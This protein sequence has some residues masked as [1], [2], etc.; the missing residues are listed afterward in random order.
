MLSCSSQHALLYRLIAYAKALVSVGRSS[1]AKSFLRN[2]FCNNRKVLLVNF[3]AK[4]KSNNEKECF[5]DRRSAMKTLFALTRGRSGQNRQ[6]ERLTVL[7]TTRELVKVQFICVGDSLGVL[8][9]SL[10]WLTVP[11]ATAFQISDL[12]NATAAFAQDDSH[13]SYRHKIPQVDCA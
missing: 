3:S 11:Y 4:R 1:F 12:V 5:A 9:K 6:R 8:S 7:G 13:R 2:T 10:I